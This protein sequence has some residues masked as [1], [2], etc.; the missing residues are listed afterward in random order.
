M[1][2]KRLEDFIGIPWKVGGRDFDGVDC[3]GLCILA[4]SYL[5]GIE[6]PDVWSY[7]A[8]DYLDMTINGLQDLPGYASQVEKPEDGDVIALRLS[9]GYVHY[10]LCVGNRMLHISEDTRS[11]LSRH[12]PQG[13]RITYWRFG[14]TKAGEL[15]WA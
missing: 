13:N 6:M 10:G 1:T 7:G 8:D 4:A 14:S 11:R 5:Y 2:T 15:T 3:A 12:I 9:A